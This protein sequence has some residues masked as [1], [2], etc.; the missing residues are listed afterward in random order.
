MDADA[1][2]DADVDV[3]GDM[4][5][6]ADADADVALYEED[7]WVSYDSPPD[8]S[9]KRSRRSLDANA[10]TVSSFRVLFGWVIL[11]QV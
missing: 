6:D 9:R 7:N 3:D 11:M 2:A 4:D 8:S 1:D 10:T 5:A